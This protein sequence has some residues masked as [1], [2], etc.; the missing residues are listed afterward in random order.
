ME[1]KQGQGAA[2]GADRRPAVPALRDPGAGRRGQSTE[3]GVRA[4]LA[5]IERTRGQL[6]DAYP[7]A[8]DPN[9]R[10]AVETIQERDS[11]RAECERLHEEARALRSQLEA[12]A[13]EAQ[14]RY[15]RLTEERDSARTEHDR[16]QA[17][18]AAIE[19]ELEQTRGLLGAGHDA[20]AREVDQLQARLRELERTQE[21]AAGQHERDR[22]SREALREELEAGSERSVGP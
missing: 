11:L 13:A 9:S 2:P 22:A 18:H 3:A 15:D 14:E 20:L 16:W 19:R 4:D 6:R 10:A 7:L 21:E 5:E 8:I 17:E 1:W 12:R